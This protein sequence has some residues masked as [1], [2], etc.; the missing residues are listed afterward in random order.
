MLRLLF[1]A[2]PVLFGDGVHDDTAAIQARLDSGAACVELPMPTKEYRIS[3]TL[4][5]GSNQELRLPK[6][7]RV[8]LSDGSDC[9]MLANRDFTNGNA[10]VT[11]SGGVWDMNNLGQRHNLSA[12][13]WMDKDA[14][15]IWMNEVR[16]RVETTAYHP[17]DG[18]HHPDYFQGVCM[19]LFNVKDLTVRDVTIRNPTTYGIQLWNV[20]DFRVDEVVFDYTWGNPAKANMDGLHLD[21]L[22]ARGRITNLHGI[23]FDDFVALNA[24]DGTD[25]PQYGPITDIEI[26]GI[27]CDYCHSAVR[28]L[29][30]NPA[31]PV[32]RVSIRNVKGRFYSYGIGLTYFHLDVKE[33]GV[34][35]DIVISDVRM[36]KAEEP[37]DGW[38]FA[39]FGVIEVEKGVDVGRLT[40]E[41]LV[42]DEDHRPECDTIRLKEGSTVKTL[43]IRDCEQ[44]NRTKEPLIFLHNRGTVGSLELSG[45]VLKSAPGANVEQ[46][47][48]T[49]IPQWP[50]KWKTLADI[51]A[52]PCAADYPKRGAMRP[53]GKV[54]A[55]F[56]DGLVRVYPFVGERERAAEAETD[57]YTE[58][59]F[60]GYYVI[61]MPKPR[62]RAEVTVSESEAW[63]RIRY[64]EYVERK[65]RVTGGMKAVFSEPVLRQETWGPDTVY[66]FAA[67]WAPLVVRVAEG[68]LTD[69]GFDFDKTMSF[70]RRAWNRARGDESHA[71]TSLFRNRQDF[72]IIGS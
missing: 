34:M 69:A 40:V 4:R 9:S 17:R 30:R 58:G 21:G 65:L 60:P 64:P 11:V 59:G 55:G 56:D 39:N 48:S 66:V 15:R 49:F 13:G 1:A 6:A 23:C 2:L 68:G 12:L 46:D 38:Q 32:R 14:R 63:F 31:H 20:R 42:R 36:S 71:G 54:R 26:D 7:A 8:R 47:A 24:T 28:L 44:V 16:E 43:V 61:E 50:P 5:L 41:R 3:R 29:S 25:N 10:R 19:R 51:S 45:T 27:D 22:C 52:W 53:G 57:K 72:G 33:R 35:D 37:A 67:G 18:R 62:I 70:A